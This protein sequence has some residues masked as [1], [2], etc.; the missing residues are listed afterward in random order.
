VP[1][2]LTS[3]FAR[4]ASK[5][6]QWDAF[7]RELAALPDSLETVVFDLAAFLMP[8]AVKASALARIVD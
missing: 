6:R 8:M 3:E 5:R 1:D 4:D 2:A 7:V